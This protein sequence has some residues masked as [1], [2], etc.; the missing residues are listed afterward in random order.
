MVKD[1]EAS[2]RFYREIIGLEVDRRFK[3]DPG[4]EIAF[5][6]S[7]ETKIELICNGSGGQSEVGA[8][9]SWG[10]ATDSLDR[11][12]AM[13]KEKGLAFTGPYQPNPSVRF[14]YLKDPDGMKVQIAENR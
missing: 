2:I 7:G 5:L 1:L 13:L 6:G 12:V 10:F 4:T 8:D 3:A 11:A 9:I 14:I